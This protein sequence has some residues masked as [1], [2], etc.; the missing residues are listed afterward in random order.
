MKRVVVVTL[1]LL[2]LIYGSSV[3]AQ[4]DQPQEA[5]T[6]GA[7]LEILWPTPISEV[8]DVIEVIGTANV[9]YMEFYRLEIVPLN[10]DF[11]VSE[12]VV[13]IPITAD[14]TNPD[15]MPRCFAPNSYDLVLS[16]FA[17]HHVDDDKKR[18]VIDGIFA[19]LEPGGMLLLGDEVVSDRPGGW[20]VVERVRSRIIH[21]QLNN[22]VILPDFWQLETTLPPQHHLPFLPGRVDDLTSWMAR[23]G[24]AVSSPIQVLGSA[25]LVGLKP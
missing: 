12:N 5:P 16:S 2:S 6:S 23:A 11:T 13:W 4:G 24:F 1:F 25:L 18:D 3:F 9:P 22:G 20:D 8:W 10:P 19:S 17:L 7:G 15:V 21:E 14:F